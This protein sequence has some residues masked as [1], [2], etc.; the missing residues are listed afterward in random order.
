MTY[1]GSRDA[2]GQKL[3]TTNPFGAANWSV[4]FDPKTLS[5]P[6]G[7]DVWHI[8]L[9][10]PAAST[11]RVFL[12]T[13]FFSNVARGDINDWDPNQVMFV[14]AGQTIYFYWDSAAAPAPAVTLFCRTPG[15]A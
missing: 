7:F 11:L 1:L 5:I 13:T 6:S 15:A 2:R 14:R 12:D 10:G 8:S 3:V 4:V 9:T